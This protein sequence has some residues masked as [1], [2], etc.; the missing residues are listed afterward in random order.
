MTMQ[1]VPEVS[2]SVSPTSPESRIVELRIRACAEAWRHGQSRAWCDLM[3]A[4]ADALEQSAARLREVE[5]KAE[6]LEYKY[7]SVVGGADELR[8]QIEAAEARCLSLES[9]LARLRSAEA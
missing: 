9:E 1:K 7:S 3:I 6:L 4:A 2:S 5:E 8:T